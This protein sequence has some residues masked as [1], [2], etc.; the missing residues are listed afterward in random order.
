[1]VSIEL[2]PFV[3]NLSLSLGRI[4]NIVIPL[5]TKNKTNYWG[6]ESWGLYD[7]MKLN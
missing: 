7:S 1:M 4:L 6:K 5:S 3:L 2:L